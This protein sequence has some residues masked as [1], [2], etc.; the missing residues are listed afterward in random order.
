MV[1]RILFGR[2]DERRRA[3]GRPID[4]NIL[5]IIE[6]NEDVGDLHGKSDLS[7]RKIGAAWVGACNVCPPF[8]LRTEL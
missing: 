5:G 7:M 1:N 2:N 6:L 4:R 3:L 8:H